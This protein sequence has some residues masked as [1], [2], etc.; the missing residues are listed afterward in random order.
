VDLS[1][2]ATLK[3]KLV[4]AKNF[5]E[6]T[7]YFL[8]HFGDDPAFLTL[9]QPTTDDF[10]EQVL[11]QVAAQLF[12]RD[13]VIQD[14]RLVRLP[15]HE[16]LHGGF[17]VGGK[18]G[19]LIYFEDERKGLISIAWSLSPPE[20]KYARFSGRPVPNSWLRSSN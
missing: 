16:F 4:T 20:T 1:K 10:I 13:V 19:T 12:Q 15:E 3:A 17:H 14:L 9:G 7:G 6:V 5:G 2:L 18:I 11:A 8:D